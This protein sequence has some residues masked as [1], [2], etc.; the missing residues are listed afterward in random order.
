M[1]KG[2]LIAQVF[3][4]RQAIPIE[5]AAVLVTRKNG[6]GDD[7]ISY[8]FTNSS[9]E[10]QKIEIEAPEMGLS[11]EPGNFEPFAVVDIR[12]EHPGYYPVIIHDAQVFANTTT[13]QQTEM[14]P[15]ADNLNPVQEGSENIFV[16]PQNL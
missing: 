7:L 1:A 8:Q 16:T 14:I 4:A 6:S 13:E 11:Q 5:N 3:T 9:G 15:V 10:T 12:I 2:Y